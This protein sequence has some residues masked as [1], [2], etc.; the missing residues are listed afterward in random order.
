MSSASHCKPLGKKPRQ[1]SF[2]D[3]L[4]RGREIVF[5]PQQFDQ[6]ILDVVNAIAGAPVSVT[7]LADATGVD[8]IF[9]SRLDANVLCGVAPDAF[10][11]YKHHWHMGVAEKTDSR[12]LI[13]GTRSG[14]EIIE[15]V[16]PLAGR[17]EC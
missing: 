8:E 10:L 2:C 7:R 6:V 17:I 14:V 4:L 12:A 3:F 13:C 5:H 16:A 9:F 11:A 15:H 1:T